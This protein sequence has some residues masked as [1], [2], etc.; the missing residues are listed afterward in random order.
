MLSALLTVA[1]LLT[2]VFANS[3]V[4]SL[5]HASTDRIT[6]R[7][8]LLTHSRGIRDSV[9]QTRQLLSSF[10]LD[11]HRRDY[12]APIR[13]EMQRIRDNLEQLQSRVTHALPDYV[14]VMQRIETTA[15][16]LDAALERIIATRLNALAQYPSMALAQESMQPL[17]REFLT[18]V[19]LALE[20][21]DSGD[22]RNSD[23]YQTLIRARHLWTQMISNFRIYLAN[24]MGSFREDT[25]KTQESDVTELHSQLIVELDRLTLLKTGRHLGLQAE[26][27][28]EIMSDAATGWI[29][30]FREVMK[31]HSND[32][33][34]A[35]ANQLKES[36]E[37]MYQDI[38]NALLSIDSAIESSSDRDVATLTSAT[39]TQEN[40]F[41]SVTAV[42]ILFIL[43]GYFALVRT[44][45]A[46]LA[47]VSRALNAEAKGESPES[48]P[49]TSVEETQDLLLAFDNMRQQ[50]H[51]RRSELEYQTLHDCLTGLLNR[52]GLEQIINNA[53]HLADTTRRSFALLMIDLDR[54]KEVNDTLG[55][56]I[57][58]RLLRE[59]ARRL[60]IVSRDPDGVARFGGDEFCLIVPN[61]GASEA[62]TAAGQIVRMLD[63][64]IE[65][66]NHQLLVGASI[67]IALYPQ[68]GETMHMLLQ[69]AD[70]AMYEAKRN[71]SGH[72]FY[73][74]DSDQHSVRRLSMVRD[75]RDA[76]ERGGLELHYQPKLEVATSRLIGVEAL[77]RWTHPVH[78]RVPPDQIIQIAEYTGLIRPLT[79]WVLDT[80]MQQCKSWR[81]LDLEISVAVN[82]SASCILEQQLVDWITGGLE[83]HGVAPSNLVLEITEGAMMADPNRSV[84]LL[85]RLSK[86][87]V[88][89]SVDDY[90][91][92]FSSLAYL[93][94]LPINELKIDRSFVMEMLSDDNDA[95]I[96]R[97]TIDLAHNLG[98]RVVAE[99]VEN[100]EIMN[101]LAM[102]GCDCA[103]GY[104]ISRPVPADVLVQ[105]RQI[106]YPKFVE[107][108]I[109]APLPA[110]AAPTPL[111]IVQRK[112]L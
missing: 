100:H 106:D 40:M 42:C 7:N 79:R 34:R 32:A 103:Q 110:P 94:R 104:L 68:D 81:A 90:G 95:T 4:T 3:H 107:S 31:L 74:A 63:R 50:V 92:G 82:I 8:Q 102:L 99:G 73:N 26:D 44:V 64:V 60:A 24:R 25:L 11:P 85:T 14:P 56:E 43:G 47:R 16:A 5:R 52:A 45:L 87:G 70:V 37:P 78:G 98:L 53:I 112:H 84:E 39:A 105:W 35:D 55:H 15:G 77:L 36:V 41:W 101:L 12:R 13:A 18:A 2:M 38:W 19:S 96:V 75:L 71:R 61:V 6:E 33:W 49:P 54:F 57:G 65:I 91:T 80:A 93:K 51:V 21:S 59:I 58:D 48:L 29:A 23:A 17:N 9:W 109:P 27:A 88:S 22:A 76:I 89:I 83:R 69:H 62:Q 97:S 1:I 72:A 86:M 46:P 111:R 20:E 30:I 66:E 28:L 67:G 10:L 108:R